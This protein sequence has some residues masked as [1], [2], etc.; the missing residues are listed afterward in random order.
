MESMRTW[1]N[2][3]KTKTEESWTGVRV[4]PAMTPTKCRRLSNGKATKEK[5]SGG[6]L[7][8]ARWKTPAKSGRALARK[9]AMEMEMVG[10]QSAPANAQSMFGRFSIR[11]RMKVVK[12]KKEDAVGGQEAPAVMHAQLG[13]PQREPHPEH[14][15]CYGHERTASMCA[16][17]MHELFK[18]LSMFVRDGAPD[19]SYPT[20]EEFVG[21]ALFRSGLDVYVHYYAMY[22]VWRAHVK[23]PMLRASCSHENYMAALMLATKTLL[24]EAY[25]AESWVEVGQ[26]IYTI[27]H[28]LENERRLCG[29]VNWEVEVEPMLVWMVEEQMRMKYGPREWSESRPTS[30]SPM[31]VSESSDEWDESDDSSWTSVSEGPDTTELTSDSTG[32]DVDCQLAA[33]ECVWW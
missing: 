20:L 17:F 29:M 18:C 25:S 32:S 10:G 22:L 33:G 4:A 16:S 7:A 13:E 2:A 9:T 15:V 23:D 11:G 27:D 14:D 1:L 28:L 31:V 21:Y 6:Q 19:A 26:S 3:L 8:P 24:P 30:V 5:T 12:K